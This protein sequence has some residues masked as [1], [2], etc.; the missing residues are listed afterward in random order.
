MSDLFDQ[1]LRN[2]ARSLP[3]PEAPS[4]LIDRV[5]A[6]RA[7]GA[8][9][10]LPNASARPARRGQRLA[11]LALAATV[12]FAAAIGISRAIRRPMQSV[13]AI[14]STSSLFT[15][16]GFFVAPAFAQTPPR[17]PGA[18]PITAFNPAVLDGKRFEYR[19]QFVDSAGR[20]TPDGTG[21]IN[22]ERTRYEGASALRVS[23]TATISA[24]ED[25]RRALAETLYV[26]ATTLRLL[27]RSVTETPYRR[28]SQIAIR[29]R[30]VGDS[31]VGEMRTD[32]NIHRP[33]AQRLTPVF[34]PY[35]SD[36]L[37]PMALAG[38]TLSPTWRGSLSVVGWA[39]RP[40]DVFYP[41][42]VW[43][44]GEETLVTAKG[45]VPCWK[46]RVSAPPE[47]RVEWVR[48]SDGI[49]IRSRDDG[50]PSSKGRREF[51]LVN[52]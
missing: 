11:L 24:E 23:H 20:I 18:P 12:V 39:V 35:I 26:E 8:R 47:Q 14:D 27:A 34:A 15:S 40:S 25:Q 32:N 17:A 36:A 16:G 50:P 4:E 22:V 46:L 2:I 10:V 38:V 1:R 43:V 44:V 6:E 28:F 52:P 9:V 31:V 45:P 42:T 13:S 33:I 3:T 21:R 19:I 29:Q 30:F 41:V 48:K 49:A 51:I 7:A 5:I 37:A